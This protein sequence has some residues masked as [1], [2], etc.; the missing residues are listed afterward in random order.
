MTTP[1][2]ELDARYSDPDAAATPW[3]AVEQALAT[4]PLYWLT[5]VR[6][7]GG[8]HQTPL[9]G[10]YVA[11]ALHFTT[12]P[13]ERKARNI[14]ANDQVLMSTG[15]NT[16]HAGLDVVVEGR[17]VRVTDADRLAVL[18]A[19]WEGKYGPEWHFDVADGAFR[20]SEGT[21]VAHVFR[22][23]ATRAYAFAKD[24]YSHTRYT[25]R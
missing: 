14:T 6:P 22:V 23:E 1:D 25:F 16:L 20:H 13:E 19:Q 15:A 24:P 12:G 4:A 21:S 10:L 18:A 8:P 3:A 17:A 9:I 7:E 5:S 2:P 11:G